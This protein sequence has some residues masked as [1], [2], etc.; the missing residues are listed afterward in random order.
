MV[1]AVAL[2][3][4]KSADNLKVKKTAATVQVGT[5]MPRGTKELSREAASLKLDNRHMKSIAKKLS[6]SASYQ[7]K[8]YREQRRARDNSVS[9]KE[10]RKK[11]FEAK[12]SAEKDRIR[13][14]TSKR[15]SLIREKERKKEGNKKRLAAQKNNKWSMGQERGDSTKS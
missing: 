1:A 13:R 8:I 6:R 4:I 5:S 3:T 10:R 12:P 14:E 2:L 11:T 7:T 15:V 9:S